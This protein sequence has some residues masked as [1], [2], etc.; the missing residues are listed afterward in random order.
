[1]AKK[2]EERQKQKANRRINKLSS[3]VQSNLDKLY[4]STF[5]SQPSNKY[6][7]DTIKSKLDDSIDNI[8][9][10]NKDNTGKATMSSLYS[11]AMQYNDKDSTKDKESKTLETLLNDNANYSLEIKTKKLN[12]DMSQ[13]DIFDAAQ[14]I[15]DQK[16]WEIK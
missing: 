9:L 12:P 6:D 16:I 14:I 1:M 4:S 15:I 11:R 10:S 5:Y 8:V 3:F 7:L 2:D 13:K